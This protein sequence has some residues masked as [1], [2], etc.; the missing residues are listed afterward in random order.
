MQHTTH[1]I[2]LSVKLKIMKKIQS[3]LVC[4]IIV[5][6]AQAQVQ[7]GSLFLGGSIGITKSNGEGGSGDKTNFLT[8]IFRHRL[9]KQLTKTRYLGYSFP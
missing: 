5:Q 2:V 3:V 9:V 4:I 8:G 1:L 6:L 7:K